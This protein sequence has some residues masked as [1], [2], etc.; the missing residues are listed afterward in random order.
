MFV[1]EKWY[2][3][4]DLCSKFYHPMI[5]HENDFLIKVIRETLNLNSS[6]LKHQNLRR[7]P[8]ISSNK[9]KRIKNFEFYLNINGSLIKIYI[10]FLIFRSG[11]VKFLYLNTSVDKLLKIHMVINMAINNL[12]INDLWFLINQVK[13]LSTL[14]VTPN[15]LTRPSWIKALNFQ[16]LII[17][18]KTSLDDW[19]S[20]I[21]LKNPKCI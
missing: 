10:K 2:G 3:S 5:T 9:N 19:D 15:E 21:T 20:I 1:T 16:C 13:N 17:S 14:W 7:S 8:T 11:Q 4:Y 12:F 18:I 6:Y